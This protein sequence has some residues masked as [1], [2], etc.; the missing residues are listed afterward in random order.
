M[1]ELYRESLLAALGLALF[2]VVS[3]IA[4]ACIAAR[5][6][7]F[8]QMG[9]QLVLTVTAL[10]GAFL[11]FCILLFGPFAMMEEANNTVV[12]ETRYSITDAAM[13]EDDQLSLT[14]EDA[15][16]KKT[17]VTAPVSEFRAS[18]NGDFLIVTEYRTQTK[19]YAVAYDANSAYA[20]I[21]DAFQLKQQIE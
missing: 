1:L 9:A 21:F 3:A 11:A 12:A 19:S 8:R 16:G 4:F 20:D 10:C 14:V 2:P 15:D 17:T 13:A 5:M 7:N 6:D 18:E